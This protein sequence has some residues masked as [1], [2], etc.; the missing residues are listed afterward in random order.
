MAENPTEDLRAKSKVRVCERYL[1]I[2]ECQRLLAQLR[3]R[4]R[5]IVRAFVQAGLRPE[6]LFALRRDDVQGDRL[7]VDEALVEGKSAP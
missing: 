6:E 5:L 2:E 4:D 7:R 1:S 3:G